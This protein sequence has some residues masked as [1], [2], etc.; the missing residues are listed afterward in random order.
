VAG[1]EGDVVYRYE[2]P[3]LDCY[4]K[5]SDKLPRPHF[6]SP[7]EWDITRKAC[8]DLITGLVHLL[9]TGT[10]SFLGP[11]SVIHCTIPFV[12]LQSGSH[13]WTLCDRDLG[14]KNIAL[15]ISTTIANCL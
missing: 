6:L 7:R 2:P 10:K 5:I 1:S 14:S 3:P 15:D 8:Y 11:S 12:D 13:S 4:T 9:V